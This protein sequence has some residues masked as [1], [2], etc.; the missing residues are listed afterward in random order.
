MFTQGAL[1]AIDAT[2]PGGHKQSPR[3]GLN[4]EEGQP[5]CPAGVGQRPP[6]ELMKGSSSQ[7]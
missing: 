6:A 1:T 2:P 7:K 3:S 4:E 5:C